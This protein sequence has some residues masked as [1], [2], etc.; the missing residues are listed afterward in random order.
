MGVLVMLH[1]VDARRRAADK[2]DI[3]RA[4]RRLLGEGD[5]LI[6]DDL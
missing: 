2:P 3:Q 4:D 1:T 6:C 5:S